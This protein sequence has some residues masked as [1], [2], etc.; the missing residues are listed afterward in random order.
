MFGISLGGLLIVVLATVAY[1][2]VSYRRSPAARRRVSRVLRLVAA[3]SALI[4]GVMWLP[5]AWSD[6]GSF[7]LVLVG[8]PLLCCLAAVLADFADMR[9][10]LTTTLAAA[11]LLVWSLITVVGVGLYFLVPAVVL[12]A[13]A[14]TSWQ[15]DRR[16]AP[17]PTLRPGRA[18]P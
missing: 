9:P 15:Q 4:I 18:A 13:A 7:G 14:V 1:V 10:A 8:V 11:A 6:S 5:F 2:G 16:P 12:A 3:A 17:D